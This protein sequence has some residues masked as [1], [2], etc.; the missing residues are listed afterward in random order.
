[1]NPDEIRKQTILALFSDDFLYER[2]VLKGGNA[3]HLV[4]QLA[5]RSSLDLDFSM[6]ADFENIEEAKQHLFSTLKKHFAALGFVIFD[7]TLNPK[8]KIEGIDER[9]RWG[10]YE[11]RFKLISREK[12]NRLQDR[13]QKMRIDALPVGPRQERNFS[14]DFSKYEYTGAKVNI[15]L[16]EYVIPVYTLEMIAAEKL[17]A[18]CQQMPDYTIEG[19]R[20]RRARD[21]YDIH[22]I[23]SERGIDLGSEVNRVLIRRVFDAKQVP[24]SLLGNVANFREFHRGDWPAVLDAVGGEA[25]SYDFYFDFVLAEVEKLKPLWVEDTPL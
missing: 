9:P 1:M 23:V 17:R 8:P 11:L 14:V 18:I 15:E 13:P 7:E 4:H 6:S 21:F 24:L 16:G 22:L 12:F 10:G 25:R 3:I 20:T 19:P 5:L 2:L